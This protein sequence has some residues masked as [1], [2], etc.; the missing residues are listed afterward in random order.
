MLTFLQTLRENG[1]ENSALMVLPVILL[2]FLLALFGR[3]F[4]FS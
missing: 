3:L 4:I 2:V 1:F